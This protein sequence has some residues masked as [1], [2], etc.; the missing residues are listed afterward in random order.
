M[1]GCTLYA[2]VYLS[3]I[4]L[5]SSRASFLFL[6][7]IFSVCV[8]GGDACMHVCMRLWSQRHYSQVPSA[9]VTGFGE[10]PDVG[11][12]LQTLVLMIE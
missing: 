7:F 3:V 11:N 4:T 6:G 1:Y 10:L 5:S 8:C 9:V 2:Y 12:G